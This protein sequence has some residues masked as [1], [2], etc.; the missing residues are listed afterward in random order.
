MIRIP[1]YSKAV[2]ITKS[3]TVDFA[4]PQAPHRCCDAIY[5]GGAGTLVVVLEDNTAITFAGA[6]AGTI[7][8]FRARRVNSTSTTATSMVA[9]Y[10]DAA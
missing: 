6:L 3:D 7:Y 2:A 5:V 8:P 1:R 9:L 4:D 10:A